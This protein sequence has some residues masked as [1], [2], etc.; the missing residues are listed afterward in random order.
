MY[1]FALQRVS[2]RYGLRIVC[3]LGTPDDLQLFVWLLFLCR[4]SSVFLGPTAGHKDA[5]NSVFKVYNKDY[6]LQARHWLNIS[7]EVCILSRLQDDR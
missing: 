5:G 4:Y 3:R 7:R 2:W 1:S 6:P